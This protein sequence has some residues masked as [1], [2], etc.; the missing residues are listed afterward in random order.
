MH[1]HL[2]EILFD[3]ATIQAKVAE[4]AAEISRDYA[5][6]KVLVVGILTGAVMFAVDLLKRLTIDV[7]LDFMDV[8]SY[9]ASLS[10]SGEVRILKDLSSAAEGREILI[11]EDIIDTGNTLVYLK[12]ILNERLARSVKIA[13]LLDK[14]A[15][16]K[17]EIEA[18]YVGFVVPDAFI[19]GYGIDYAQRYRQLPY[20]GIFNT[21]FMIKEEQN[22]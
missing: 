19:V 20:I 22:E 10:S 21:D 8:S 12:R 9:G 1:P 14:P 6:K 3:E 11:V 5:G 13:A 4:M 15:G 7:E 18:D 2:K 16:R 17:V